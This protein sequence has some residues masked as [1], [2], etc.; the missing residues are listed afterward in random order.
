MGNAKNSDPKPLFLTPDPD[1]PKCLKR[2]ETNTLGGNFFGFLL[3]K[4]NSD[5]FLFLF[6]CY[7]FLYVALEQSSMWFILRTQGNP[8]SPV[9]HLLTFWCSHRA[10]LGDLDAC[11]A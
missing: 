5:L 9:P 10:H 3:F 7:I 6:S 11:L 2:K 4:Q 8:V 1:F